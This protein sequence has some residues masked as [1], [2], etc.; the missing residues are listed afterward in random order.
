MTASGHPT[1]G[2]IARHVVAATEDGARVDRCLAAALA[3]SHPELSRSRIKALIEQGNLRMSAAAGGAAATIDEASYRV[4]PGQELAL[5]I[6]AAEAAVPLGQEIALAIVYEDKDLIVIDKPAGM[7]VHPAPGNPD[8]TLVNALIA[9]CGESLSGIGGVKRPGIVHRIDKDTSGLVVAAKNDAAHQVLSAA[10][11]AH[12]IE[13]EYRCFVWG[14]PSPKAG[15][16]EGNIGRHGIDRKR[17]AIV[18][19]GGKPAVTHYRTLAVFGLGAAE[20]ACNLETGR[21]HQIRVHL[22]AI[23]HPLIGDTTYGKVTPARRAKLP[24][25][26]AEFAR[27][28]PRQALHAAVLGFAHPRTGKPMRWETPLPADL[29]ELKKR[30]AG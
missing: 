28:F 11:A 22:A 29:V 7:V 20:L 3:A 14:L 1:D 4:K 8:N 27:H 17:M 10:F 19:K 23:G 15:T 21:T 2:Q 24:P 26:A 6:P 12:D 25:E 30:L 13:R 5:T 9:H 18:R 16:I